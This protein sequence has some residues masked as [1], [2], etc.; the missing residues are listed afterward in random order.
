[1]FIN[2]LKEQLFGNILNNLVTTKWNVSL[3]FLWNYRAD[4]LSTD[5]FITIRTNLIRNL[6]LGLLCLMLLFLY[7]HLSMK[8]FWCW[9]MRRLTGWNSDMRRYVRW[10]YFFS[11]CLGHFSWFVFFSN[12][13]VSGNKT[14]SFIKTRIWPMKFIG[15]QWSSIYNL[16]KDG[17]WKFSYLGL[18]QL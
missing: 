10:L 9:Q 17:K 2:D 14:A 13:Y 18:F 8:Y 7:L 11:C 3:N 1:M 15:W 6:R 16:V 5:L 12:V 4:L